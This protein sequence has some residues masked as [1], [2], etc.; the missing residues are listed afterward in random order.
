MCTGIGAFVGGGV[1]LGGFASLGLGLFLPQLIG[2]VGCVCVGGWVGGWVWVWVWGWVG[3]G[4]CVDEDAIEAGRAQCS[5]G[6]N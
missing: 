4:V 5:L 3:V 1:L 2:L 6:C